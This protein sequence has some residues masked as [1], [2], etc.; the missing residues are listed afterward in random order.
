MKVVTVVGNRPQFVKAAPLSVAFR[1]A[2]ID[3]TVEISD[4]QHLD[5]VIKSLKSVHGVLDVERAGRAG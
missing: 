2:G 4:V 5:R 3:V 1:E